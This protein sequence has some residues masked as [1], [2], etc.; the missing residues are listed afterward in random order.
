MRHSLSLEFWVPPVSILDLGQHYCSF[1]RLFLR[2][3]SVCPAQSAQ[4]K[5]P[6]TFEDMMQMKRLGDTAVSPDGKWLAYAVT[7]VD[8]VQNT[9]T[10]SCGCR[11]LRAANRMKLAVAQPGDPASSSLLTGKRI[12][13]LSGR[14]GGQQMWI[15]DFDPA[16]GAASNAKKLTAIATEADNAKWSPDWR[17]IVFTSAVY[18]DCPAITMADFEAGTNAMRTAMRRWLRAR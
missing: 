1:L 17:S 12:L 7:T 13:F 4:P 6:M 8:L 9:K 5:R 16:T 18:P 14:D 11:R 3:P 10:R 2:G 15:A